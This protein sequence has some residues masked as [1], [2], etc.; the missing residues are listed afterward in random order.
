MG[1]PCFEDSLHFT[2]ILT[3]Q[4]RVLCLVP[5]RHHED[6]CCICLCP[7]GQRKA[8]LLSMAEQPVSS[9][10]NWFF[11]LAPP[12]SRKAY[13]KI[14]ILFLSIPELVLKKKTRILYFP[15]S[16][17]KTL[18]T[19][20][21]CA[22]IVVASDRKWVLWVMSSWCVWG[23]L[24]PLLV[25]IFASYGRVGRLSKRLPGT[26][27]CH[28]A[29]HVPDNFCSRECSASVLPRMTASDHMIFFC[30]IL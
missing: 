26:S 10:V 7:S 9:G 22:T 8:A 14:V 28:S 23:D 27:S 4:V 6:F 21:S 25:I 15:K 3:F 17:T 30:L 13:F 2:C 16:L 12:C 20:R 18:K 19:G 1:L 24:G 5:G 11:T 29:G